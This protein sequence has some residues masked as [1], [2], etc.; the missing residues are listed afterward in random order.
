MQVK[1]WEACHAI[2][3]QS[4]DMI[5][6]KGHSVLIRS[7]CILELRLAGWYYV[8]VTRKYIYLAPSIQFDEA[9]ILKTCLEIRF[10]Q[11]QRVSQPSRGLRVRVQAPVVNSLTLGD[12]AVFLSKRRLLTTG[13]FFS[14]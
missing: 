9:N 6:G 11:R 2:G 5:N 1:Q 14:G 8:A 7:F 10:P 13:I 12:K 4:S 3:R